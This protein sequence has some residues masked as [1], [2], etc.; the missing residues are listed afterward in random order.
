MVDGGMVLVRDDAVLSGND[1]DGVFGHFLR[2]GAVG[3]SYHVFGTD[4]RAPA[5]YDV[6]PFGLEPNLQGRGHTLNRDEIESNL[7]VPGIQGC[8]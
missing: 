3:S 2:I 1:V 8:H 4:D 6:T 5:H 7:S